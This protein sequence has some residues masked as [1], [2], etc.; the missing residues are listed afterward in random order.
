MRKPT[1]AEAL[2]YL[3]KRALLQQGI[4]QKDIRDDGD[5]ELLACVTSPGPVQMEELLEEFPYSNANLRQA[6]EEMAGGETAFERD[7]SLS[8]AANGGSVIAFGCGEE[9]ERVV[10]DGVVQMDEHGSP[11]TRVKNPLV[12]TMTKVGRVEAKVLDM[13]VLDQG[14]R[15]AI[16]SQIA[17]LARKHAAATTKEEGAGISALLDDRPIFVV[18]LGYMLLQAA[19]AKVARD[20][21]KS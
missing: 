2:S 9:M 17:D 4:R 19:R 5:Y 1:Y 8:P 20:M 7:D 15:M 16:P 3:D 12:L 6:F 14:R 11:K 21:G 13:D 10:V 18:R